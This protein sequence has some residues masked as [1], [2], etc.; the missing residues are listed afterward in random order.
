MR[1]NNPNKR[2]K[3]NEKKGRTLQNLAQTTQITIKTM[4]P[5]FNLL[6]IQFPRKP[7][8]TTK[9]GVL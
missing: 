9:Q 4:L 1:E 8:T 2:L 6:E 5:A 7:K 3:R